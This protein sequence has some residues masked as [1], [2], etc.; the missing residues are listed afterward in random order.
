MC[1]E[2]GLNG[3]IS[4]RWYRAFGRLDFPVHRWMFSR[5]AVERILARAGLTI[6][7]ARRF[8][9]VPAFGLVLAGRVAGRRAI[10]IAGYPHDPGGLPPAQNAVHRLYD[11]AMCVLRYRIGRL[12]PDI[13]PQTMFVAARAS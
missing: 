3:A 11:R 5:L 10:Q 7:A 4:P 6:V 2:V 1:F 9:L 12:A 8:G 13:G